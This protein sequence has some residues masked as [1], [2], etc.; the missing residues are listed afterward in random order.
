MAVWRWNQGMYLLC[1]LL[2][3]EPGTLHGQIPLSVYDSRLQK[4]IE[5]LTCAL[6]QFHSATNS[7][8]KF[9]IVYSE[10]RGCP[11]SGA[12]NMLESTTLIIWKP[13]PRK[14]VSSTVSTAQV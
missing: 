8:R 11:P 10:A 7:A 4:L 13:V 2:R 3:R 1:S 5:M 9:A 6:D 12:G 14:M